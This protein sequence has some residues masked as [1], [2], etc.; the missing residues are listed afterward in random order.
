MDEIVGDPGAVDDRPSHERPHEPARNSTGSRERTAPRRRIVDPSRIIS[1]PTPPSQAGHRP[2]RHQVPGF[3]NRPTLKNHVI[4]V[5]QYITRLARPANQDPEGLYSGPSIQA[6]PSPKN[7]FFQIGAS[8][9]RI[10]MAAAQPASASLRCGAATA[11]TTLAS[12]IASRP[13]R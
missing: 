9:L 5:C 8:D 6:A 4:Y 13:M 2:V 11:I 7:S 1:T 12:P 10:S 3:E